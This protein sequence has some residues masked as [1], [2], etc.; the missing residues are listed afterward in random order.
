MIFLDASVL[1]AVTQVNHERHAPSRELWE[2]CARNLASVSA[3]AIADV[4]NLLTAMPP[5][6]RLGPRD[7]LLVA[8]TFLQR[9]TSVTLSPEECTATLRRA[10][11]QGLT[12]AAIYD[13]FHLACAR[14]I[15]ARQIYTWN[16]RQFQ[17]VA[18]DLT[19]RIVTP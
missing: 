10:A 6:L 19:E 18:P 11:N 4:Y 3:Y 15:E 9:L 8:E 2:R 17:M 7:A 5:H 1:I 12:G 16:V 13:A 14:K